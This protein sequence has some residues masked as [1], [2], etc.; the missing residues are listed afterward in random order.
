MA[1]LLFLACTDLANKRTDGDS[2]WAVE[3]RSGSVTDTPDDS[4]L[5]QDTQDSGPPLPEGPWPSTSTAEAFGQ[6]DCVPTVDPCFHRVRLA[7]REVGGEWTVFDGD[8][9]WRA[10]VP[11]LFLID[12]GEVEGIPMASLWVTYVDTFSENVPN[13]EVVSVLS[14]AT[15]AFP[16][17]E[18][19]DLESLRAA[20]EGRGRASWRYNTTNSASLGEYLFDPERE[21]FETSTG[22]LHTLMVLDPD[23]DGDEDFHQRSLILESADGLNFTLRH[24]ILVDDALV[25]P[26]LVPLGFDGLY[27]AVLPEDWAPGGTGQWAAHRSGG[28][29]VGRLMGD[30][31]ALEDT[32]ETLYGAAVPS[33]TLRD[34]VVTV[35]GHAADEEHS[36]TSSARLVSSTYDMSFG[37]L[38]EELAPTAETDT[39][40]GVYAPSIVPVG[41]NLE[42]MVFHTWMSDARPE[43]N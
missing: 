6:E 34:G 15:L 27:P 32:N 39:E 37:A 16:T 2:G 40:G 22:L 10:S 43:Q 21:V 41:D 36:S 20:V 12:H 24:E 26:D 3:D 35:Y 9:V 29:M 31:L 42:L 4:G 1:L 23:L 30:L 8:L 19:T 17:A 5:T 28:G 18:A 33:S 13:D 11:N 25:D 7:G 38:T 14:V